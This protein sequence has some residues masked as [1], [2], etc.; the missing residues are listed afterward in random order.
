M[1]L[2]LINCLDL[3]ANIILTNIFIL[4][5]LRT[6]Y[7]F[8][9]IIIVPIMFAI[10]SRFGAIDQN[11]FNSIFFFCERSIIFTNK[12]SN[13]GYLFKTTNENFLLVF[14]NLMNR[15]INKIFLQFWRQ[16]KKTSPYLLFLS[17]RIN[18]IVSCYFSVRT[19]GSIISTQ[20]NVC[21]TNESDVWAALKR[22]R[23]SR[24]DRILR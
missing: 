2:N 10:E 3:V 17:R 20:C 4:N 1:L 13:V 16:T 24:R 8:K 18:I 6:L 5:V 19:A 23:H 9:F 21:F 14:N 7:N 12:I 11:Q 22:A 15:R